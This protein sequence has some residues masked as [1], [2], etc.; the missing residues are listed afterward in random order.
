[1]CKYIVIYDVWSALVASR[2]IVDI[3]TAWHKQRA[4][5]ALYAT[6]NISVFMD[7]VLG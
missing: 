5:D 3:R 2:E 1:M 7:D 4:G 6:C